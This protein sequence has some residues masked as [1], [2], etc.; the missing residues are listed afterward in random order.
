MIKVGSIKEFREYINISQAELSRKT[1]ISQSSISHWEAGN[2]SFSLK[3]F[4]KIR[5]FANDRGYDI[6]FII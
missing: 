2:F 5:K 3:S 4:M 6:E 1:G